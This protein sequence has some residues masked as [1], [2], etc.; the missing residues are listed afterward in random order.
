MDGAVKIQD[1]PVFSQVTRRAEQHGGVTV[2][3][4]GMHPAFM[5]GTMRKGILFKQGQGIEVGTQAD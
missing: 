3:T 5:P 4:A 1:V 2:V